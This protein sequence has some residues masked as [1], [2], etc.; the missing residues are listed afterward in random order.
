M[1]FGSRLG[2]NPGMT[3][4][5]LLRSLAFVTDAVDK[6]VAAVCMV[7]LCFVVCANGAEIVLRGAANQS[8]GWLYETNLLVANWL[9]FLGMSLVYY[10]NKDIVLDFVMMVLRGRSRALYLIGVNL[11]GIATFGV[12][13]FFTVR[14]MQL[15]LPFRT[16]GFGLP[17]VLYT[18]PVALSAFAMALSLA[19]HSVEIWQRGEP[20]AGG[21]HLPGASVE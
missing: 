7:L 13:A 18:L 10:R 19:R 8:L 5:H 15:Q 14:L 20:F 9:Y 3:V 11:V 6:A 21:G 12:I 1:D 16:P 17:N 4:E 2:G